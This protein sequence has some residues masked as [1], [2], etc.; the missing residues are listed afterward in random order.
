MIY[1]S[2]GFFF[3]RSASGFTRRPIPT[4][5]RLISQGIKDVI[6]I[7]GCNFHIRLGGKP[8]SRKR[9][10]YGA[11]HPLLRFNPS[12]PPLRIHPCI[13][14]KLKQGCSART[15]VQG[16]FIRGYDLIIAILL[17][18]IAENAIFINEFDFL[19]KPVPNAYSSY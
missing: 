13:W 6:I 7:P 18:E 17:S 11:N 10:P 8:R 5:P 19:D 15:G 14:N 12:L 1:P 3:G 2:I 9:L 4:L 16:F